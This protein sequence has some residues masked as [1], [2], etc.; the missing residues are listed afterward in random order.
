MT[1]HGRYGNRVT[2]T[3]II[4]FVELRIRGTDTVALIDAQNHRLAAFL[5]HIG[6]ILIGSHHAAAQ[7]RHQHDHIRRGNG[8]IG[9]RTHLREDHI[10]RPRLNT[11]GIHQ[12]KAVTQPLTVAVNAVP[13]HAGLVVH[14]GQTGAYQFIKKCGFAHVGAAHNG[15]NR[16]RHNRPSF[17]ANSKKGG[18]KPRSLFG[19][20]QVRLCVEVFGLRLVLAD[21]CLAVVV[22][23]VGAHFVRHGVAGAVGALNESRR[24][25][26]PNA[27]TSFVLSCL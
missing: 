25:Q 6:H 2:H 10:I 12:Q 1:V 20:D 26:L 15:N 22:T 4:K 7:I 23:A 27:G 3:Q 5:Q 8:N 17:Q 16:S 19:C 11:A 18:H 24:I 9:L 14:N 13:G 21:N